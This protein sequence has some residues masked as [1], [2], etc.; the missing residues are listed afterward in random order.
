MYNSTNRHY[1]PGGLNLWIV[2]NSIHYG[3]IGIRLVGGRFRWG[4]KHN[5]GNN[6]GQI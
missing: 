5:H 4:S 1:I 3:I 2:F 6:Q